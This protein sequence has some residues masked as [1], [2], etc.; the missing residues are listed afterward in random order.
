LFVNLGGVAPENLLAAGVAVVDGAAFGAPGYARMA[1][2]GAADL[3]DELHSRLA[4]AT[5]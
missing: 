4:L 3:A 5:S 1:F 2:G